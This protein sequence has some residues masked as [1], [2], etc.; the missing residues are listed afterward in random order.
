MTVLF[1]GTRS[2]RPARNS[3]RLDANGDGVIDEAETEW[4]SD[5]IMDRATALQARL[6]SEMRRIDTSGDGK[7]SRDEFRDR[8]LFSDLADRDG[9]GKLSAVEFLVIPRHHGR[10]LS[11]PRRYEQEL[12]Q[13]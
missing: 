3:A 10:S 4:L 13:Y 2:S 12:N 9:D 8:T 11:L 1:R 6:G 7:V 5:A